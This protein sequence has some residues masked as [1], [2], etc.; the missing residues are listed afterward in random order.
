M[1]LTE[2]SMLG[3]RTSVITFRHPGTP[4]RFTLIP[5]IHFGR[6]DYYRRIAR[7]V[8]ACA[9]VV[10]ETYDGP[11]S[12]GL[13]YVTAMRLS[14]QRRAGELVHQDIDYRSLGVPAVFPDGDPLA[15]RRD[16]IPATGWADVVMMVPYLTVTMTVGGRDWL[17]RRNFEISDDSEPRAFR[18]GWL[19]R[20]FLHDRDE[21]LVAELERVHAERGAD[22]IEV[23][24]VWGAAHMPAVVRA[25]AGRLG[26]RPVSGGDWL[27][28]I[29]F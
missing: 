13:A 7:R 16:R 9:M 28:A 24:V 21:M 12:T 6:A 25:L 10:A 14:L 11:S 5:T 18:A 8:A 2:V 4:L 26:Y 23:A 20:M 22:P 15:V 3:V 1:Q 17:L 19:N 27:T 29:D